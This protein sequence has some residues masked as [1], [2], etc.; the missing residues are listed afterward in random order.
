MKEYDIIVIGSGPGGYATAAQAASMGMRVMIVERDRLGGT[1]LNRGCI[2]TKSLCRS[3]EVALTV[4]DAAAFGV[5]VGVVKFNYARAAERK[6]QVVDELREGVATILK[7]VDIVNG[8]ACF[9]DA[10]TIEV[11]GESFTAPKIIVAT[12]SRPALLDI[13]GAEFAVNSDFV[14]EMTELPES[15]VIIGGGVIGMEFAS[16]FNAFGVEV[17]VLE[18]CREILPGFDAEIAKRLRMSLKRRG[19][20]IVTGAQVTE[21]SPGVTVSYTEKDRQKTIDAAMAV[22]AVGR[23][24]VVPDGLETLGVTIERGFVSVDDSM[25]TSV[26]GI[27]AIGDVNGRCLLAHAATAQGRVA[28]GLQSLYNVMPAAVF[29]LPE[30]GT[31]GLTAERCEA[32][33]RSVVVGKATYRSNGKALAAGQPD[34]MVKIIADAKTGKIVGFH[35]CGAHAAD[36]VQEVAV[37][38]QAGMTT[39][40]LTETVHIHPTL[41]ELVEAATASLHK[42]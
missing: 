30:C 42:Y 22:M 29:T 3:A 6:N 2:P 25:M 31:V 5:D 40:Q 13:P 34:G 9:V 8:E 41:S 37:A 20:S 28:L 38:M 7:D 26:S 10:R 16:V 17:T 27:Y 23:K 36:L 18:Y 39:E 35:V 14:L 15:V 24:A 32:L 33:G 19:I 4:A 11:N 1:C 21:I 12:G